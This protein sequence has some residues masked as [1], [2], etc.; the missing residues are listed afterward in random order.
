MN[1]TQNQAEL[2][3]ARK[4]LKLGIAALAVGGLFS[5]LLVM[6]RTPGVQELIPFRNFFKTAL[7]VHVDLTIL[8][9]FL[10]F[11]GFASSLFFRSFSMINFS[12][13]LCMIAAT[14]FMSLPP[15]MGDAM[16]LM[17]NYIPV[18][19][20]PLFIMAIALIFVSLVLVVLRNFSAWVLHIKSGEKPSVVNY[21]MISLSFSAFSALLCF[22]LAGLEMPEYSRGYNYYEMLFWAGGHVLQ[23]L[24]AG[25]M[26]FCWLHLLQRL[27]I[28]QPWH[29][30]LFKILFLLNAIFASL[31]VILYLYSGVNDE[32]YMSNFTIYKIAFA[33][34]APSIAWLAVSYALIKSDNLFIKNNRVILSFLL[35]SLALFATGGIISTFIQGSNSIIP[36][37]YHGMIVAVTLAVMGF[38][39]VVLP[40]IGYG[41][42]NNRWIFAQPIIY[43][44][45]QIL[46]VIGLAWSGG[47]GAVRKSAE[48]VTDPNIVIGMGMMGA[49]GMLAIIAGLIFVIVVGRR[50]LKG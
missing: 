48:T 15:F 4:W 41:V 32:N 27:Q 39:V 21:A 36:A 10:C 2:S 14:I 50:I 43:G 11:M 28:L 29:D 26:M 16:P 44:V 8:V 49:G 23:I 17:N 38:V 46:H 31:G 18:L 20:T 19:Q 40:D 37:H 24:Y 47:Y 6:A 22:A 9:W 7:V 34:F 12:A 33:G 13:L 45:G 42:V 25:C 35:A 30:R 1:I 3:H 5:V